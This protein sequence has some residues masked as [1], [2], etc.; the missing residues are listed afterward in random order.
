M[1]TYFK[2]HEDKDSFMAFFDNELKSWKSDFSTSFVETESGRSFVIESG[3]GN[4]ETIFFIHGNGENAT[5]AKPLHEHLSRDYRVISADVMWQ[6]NRSIP[7]HAFDAQNGYNKWITE[8]L[9]YY[10]IEKVIISGLSYGAWIALEYAIKNP[11]R[12]Q[13]SILMSPAAC[14]SSVKLGYFFKL[15]K[16]AIFQNDSNFRDFLQ[17]CY[18]RKNKISDFA[19]NQIALNFKHCNLSAPPIVPTVYSDQTL[20]EIPFP[21]LLIM[22]SDEKITDPIKSVKRAEKLIPYCETLTI[23]GAAHYLDVSH[24]QDM[25]TA[26]RAFI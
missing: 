16:M 26:F 23:K 22:G 11:E 6:V 17:Y 19:Y 5:A 3:Q 21:L 4:L 9:D 24:T 25:I 13:K 7:L 15:Y 8:L 1:N 20:K 18:G 12:I 14:F 2:S 10:K